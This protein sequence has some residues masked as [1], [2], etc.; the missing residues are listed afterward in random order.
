MSMYYNNQP[1][2][3]QNNVPN[4]PAYPSN[5]NYQNTYYNNDTF[6]PVPIADDIESGNQSLKNDYEL[7][8][9]LGF[10]KKVYGILSAQL[11]VTFLLCIFSMTNKT[12]A[13]FQIH[14]SGIMIFC[15]VVNIIIFICLICIPHLL[16]TTPTNYI[17]LFIFTITEAYMVSAICSMTNPQI[18]VMAAGMT[19][20]MTLALTYYACTTK[21]DFTICGSMLFIGA[22]I[23]LFFSIF[24]IFTQNPIVHIIVCCFGVLLYSFYLV[25]D[26]QLLLGNKRSALDYDDYIMG[27]LM[28]Y[29]D[30][31]Q[32]F[33][34]LLDILQKVSGEN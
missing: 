15:M 32:L 33:L 28:L 3:P 9:R 22:C 7:T 29:V 10:I 34:Y 5:Q 16:K 23:L 8:M 31:I 6:Q 11:L 12:F 25:Y 21:E 27:A 26:T 17:L 2:Q 14:N 13:N 24:L 20:G 30:I 4:P 19:V 1:N 18:V